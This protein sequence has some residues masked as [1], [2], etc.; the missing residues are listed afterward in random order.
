MKTWTLT[1]SEIFPTTNPFLRFHWTKRDKL[2][3][4]WYWLLLEQVVLH[5][6]GLTNA[7]KKRH[8]KV[9][10]YRRGDP[11][12]HN[13]TTP[14]DKLCLDNFIKL[15]VLVND[16]KKWCKLEPPESRPAG[17]LGKRTVIEIREG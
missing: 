11:D 2:I 9:I 17:K 1:I 7:R 8:V 6:D 5:S 10:S 12:E 3:K 14:M 15:G 4:E 13:L 16:N